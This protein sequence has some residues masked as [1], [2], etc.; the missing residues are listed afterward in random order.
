MAQSAPRSRIPM[1]LKKLTDF[2]WLDAG[3]AR[4]MGVR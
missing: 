1:R 4:L 3:G 2:A